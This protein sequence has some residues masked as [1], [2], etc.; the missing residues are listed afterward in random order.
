MKVWH[1][2]PKNDILIPVDG[3]R[4]VTVA[5]IAAD[6][7]GH[8]WHVRTESPYAIGDMDLLRD[9]VSRKL[10]LDGTVSVEHRVTSVFHGGDMSLAVPDNDPLRQV[11]DIST[12]DM[13]GYGIPHE[14]CYDS[15][16]DVDDE[17]YADED[18][19]KACQSA[20]QPGTGSTRTGTKTGGDSRVWM[21]RAFGGDAVAINDVLGE[22]QNDVILKGKVVKVEFRELKSK[23]ILLTF[24]MADSTNGISAKKFLDVSNQGG[25]GKFRRK[26]TLTPE[27]YDN[28]VKKLKPGVYVRVHGNIQYDNYQN[29]YVLMA[30]DMMEA[31]GGTVEREDHNPTPRVELHL[32]TVMSDMDALI[33]V[34]QLIKTIKKW[35]HPAVAVTDHG[36]VQSFPLLQEI[37]TDKTNNVKVIYGMEGYL[38]DDKIDQSYHIIILAKNQIGIRNLYKLVS[39]SH[40]KYI[41]RGRP[42][43]PPG[44]PVR[45]PRR[46]HPG[47]GL[48][49]RRAGPLDGPE[50]AAL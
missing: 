46:P 48:R 36:V 31:D 39:I 5:S 44:G 45:I 42:R 22:E 49:S 47:L 1:I 3:G 32:H 37:S 23:R 19:K 11:A 16:Y 18:Y 2:V 14:D 35:G 13:E 26:N 24:Q 41:Y 33:T 50:E 30:Y 38:F 6:L 15:I 43:I 12:D 9:R 29:D 8:A 4:S 10:G 21:G 28:L 20:F 17:L 40:L 34:K 27:E 7:A 25:G